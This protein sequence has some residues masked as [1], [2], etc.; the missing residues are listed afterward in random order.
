M[1][2]AD[3]E[4]RLAIVENRSKEAA[5]EFERRRQ[6]TE[7]WSPLIK[8]A[9][10]VLPDKMTLDGMIQWLPDRPPAKRQSFLNAGGG[11]SD[12]ACAILLK[13]LPTPD[14]FALESR[15]VLGLRR[16]IIQAFPLSRLLMSSQGLSFDEVMTRLHR[17][18]NRFDGH[19]HYSIDDT[20]EL[21]A[22]W[23]ESGEALEPALPGP[24][25]QPWYR[26]G[27]MV[28][29]A[30]AASSQDHRSTV[31]R[32]RWLE[33]MRR[34][35]TGREDLFS[36]S[37][38]PVVGTD[39]GLTVEFFPDNATP[40]TIDVRLVLSDGMSD[41]RDED[42]GEIIFPIGEHRYTVVVPMREETSE[43]IQKS[44]DRIIRQVFMRVQGV[45]AGQARRLAALHQ[46]LNISQTTYFGMHQAPEGWEIVRELAHDNQALPVFSLVRVLLSSDGGQWLQDLAASAH[47]YLVSNPYISAHATETLIDAFLPGPEQS[48]R[49]AQF[50][51]NYLPIFVDYERG[52]DSY[53]VIRQRLN[54]LFSQVLLAAVEPV[55]YAFYLSMQ[56]PAIPALEELAM[57]D[58]VVSIASGIAAIPASSFLLQAVGQLVRATKSH[59]G[60]QQI[61]NQAEAHFKGF[62]G[63]SHHQDFVAGILLWIR[64]KDLFHDLAAA[65]QNGAALHSA[66]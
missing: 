33:I 52:H 56:A 3:L 4:R 41:P 58:V 43:Q 53:R 62:Y 48:S 35:T 17:S 38:T 27:R 59:P 31:I 14:A 26:L 11:R 16:Q 66:A 6:K 46:E 36:Y 30:L 47:S 50:T 23:V 7:L 51:A 34:E 54:D 39:E 10:G 13:S 29:Y 9:F 57:T 2:V 65:V 42:D 32:Q 60:V 22:Q 12:N 8:E 15:E 24:V 64:D 18:L 61:V 55:Q 19:Q 20:A 63:T 40:V 1:P 25:S 5:A 49:Q 45:E 28:N 44:L 37:P 21:Y